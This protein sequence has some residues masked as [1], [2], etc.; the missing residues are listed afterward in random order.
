MHWGDAT[1][2]TIAIDEGAR[3]RECYT[4]GM[5]AVKG[6]EFSKGKFVVMRMGYPQYLKWLGTD[7]VTMTLVF[8][9]RRKGW[10]KGRVRNVLM[11][12]IHMN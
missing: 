8:W 1:D 3:A 6:I 12:A 7:H 4:C 11:E 9:Y 5:E 2:A 10:K